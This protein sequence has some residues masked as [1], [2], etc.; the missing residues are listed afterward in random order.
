MSPAARLVAR[1]TLFTIT[2]LCA[3]FIII[4]SFVGIWMDS[5]SDALGSNL[6]DT[7]LVL[8]IIGM[9]TGGIGA[10]LGGKR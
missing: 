2:A 7:G 4:A 6:A 8:F 5:M 10:G 9:V 3:T 1:I